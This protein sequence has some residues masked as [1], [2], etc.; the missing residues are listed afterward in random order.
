M[1]EDV[2]K[3]FDMMVEEKRKAVGQEI[4]NIVDEIRSRRRNEIFKARDKA[5]KQIMQ[6]LKPGT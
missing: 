4:A 6:L 1:A 3:S 2:L 5:L